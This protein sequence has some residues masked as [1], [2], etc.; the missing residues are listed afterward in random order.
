MKNLWKLIKWNAP[1]FILL[2]FI[3][4]GF[5]A[6]IKGA[7][8]TLYMGLFFIGYASF[9]LIKKFEMQRKID[10]SSHLLHPPY[11]T[12]FVKV[13]LWLLGI[14]GAITI[15]FALKEIINV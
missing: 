3:I 1:D 14:G 4:A 8:L 5:I 6:G 13:I 9:N 11:K 12:D 2:P 7:N 10:E 15:L